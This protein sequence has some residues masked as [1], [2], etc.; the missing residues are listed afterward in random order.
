[1]YLVYLNVLYWIY[2]NRYDIGNFVV[3]YLE[4]FFKKRDKVKEN[5][6][7]IYFN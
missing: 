4:I 7:K 2:L 3:F 6:N 1:M 5:R